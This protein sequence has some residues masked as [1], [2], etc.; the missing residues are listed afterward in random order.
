MVLAEFFLYKAVSLSFDCEQPISKLEAGYQAFLLLN[1]STFFCKSLAVSRG[2]I[3]PVCLQVRC[4][5]IALY[6][7]CVTGC[8]HDRY[9]FPDC[10]DM[11]AFYIYI[12]FAPIFG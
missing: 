5:G 4:V 2:V 1:S 7:P 6:W 9:L 8:S 3:P 11:Q 10:K 12:Y